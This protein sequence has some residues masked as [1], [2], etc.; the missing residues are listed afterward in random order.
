MLLKTLKYELI[1]WVLAIQKIVPGRIGCILRSMMFANGD[2]S[3][4]LWDGFQIDYPSKFKVGS[5]TSINRKAIIHC[6]GGV[7][8]G[9]DVLIGPNVVI[10]SQNHKIQD[11]SSLISEQGYSHKEVK[12]G[13]NVWIASNVVILPGVDIGSGAVLGAGSIVSKDIP[14]NEVWAGNPARFIK[15]RD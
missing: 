13:D 7:E 6:G 1:L 3:V 4:K 11:T 8:I 12:V 5:R 14:A 2:L 15:R 10:Y 9:E